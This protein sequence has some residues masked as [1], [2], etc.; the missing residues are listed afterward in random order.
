MK[1]LF[2]VKQHKNCG[3]ETVFD[4]L[5]D[6]SNVMERSRKLCSGLL[7]GGTR[8]ATLRSVLLLCV[9]PGHSGYVKDG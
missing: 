7:D 8:F 9:V 2:L 6:S 1:F 4:L 3:L 5:T